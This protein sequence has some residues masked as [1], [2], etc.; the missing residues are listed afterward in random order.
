[1]SLKETLTQAGRGGTVCRGKALERRR[2]RPLGGS[3]TDAGHDRRAGGQ[4]A[5][6]AL[7]VALREPRIRILRRRIIM[8]VA[9]GL[10]DFQLRDGVE[11]D[12]AGDAPAG[13]APAM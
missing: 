11:V 3:G 1:M 7:H 8:G 4:V 2:F 6:H 9:Q 12:K 13:D 5:E 10:E